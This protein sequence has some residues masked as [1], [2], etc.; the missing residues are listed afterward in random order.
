MLYT[1]AIAVGQARIADLHAQAQRDALAR[2]AWRARHRHSA[3][4]APGFLAALTR[5]ARRPAAAPE[6]L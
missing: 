5:W 4:G 3:H 2:A 1:T 6:S